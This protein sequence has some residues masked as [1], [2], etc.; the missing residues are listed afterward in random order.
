MLQINRQNLPTSDELLDSDDTPVDNED[1]NFVPNVLLFLLEYIWKSRDDWFFAV[2]MGVYHT[3]GL[4]PRVPVV[5]DGFLSL[6]VE[7][8]KG[9]GSRRS[10]VVW[11]ERDIVP[12]LTIEVVS[13]AYGSEYEDKLEVY[14]KLGVLYYVI[15]NPN[16]WRRDGHLPLEVYKL[17]DGTYQLQLGEPLWMPEI[18]LGIG[19][20]VLPSDRLGREVLSWFDRHSDRYLTT[21]ERAERAERLA[22]KL[23]ELG[24]DLDL[25]Y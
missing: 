10:Y 23:R 4:N 15:Y 12:I 24:E 17:V 6:G 14:R 11:E 20:C 19:R 7:R 9:G 2:D 22:A 13:H 1:Q 21:D 3:T 8:R 16:F 5:P 25:I 18:G